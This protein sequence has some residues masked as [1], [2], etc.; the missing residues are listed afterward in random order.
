LTGTTA[1]PHPR[2]PS[3]R[4][5]LLRCVCL[6]N[7]ALTAFG[8]PAAAGLLIDG[9]RD[10]EVTVFWCTIKRDSTPLGPKTRWICNTFRLAQQANKWRN[11]GCEKRDLDLPGD[12]FM[13]ISS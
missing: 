1:T 2:L 11:T 6:V 5:W 4:Y 3:P 7:L 10:L 8:N 9:M 12:P 13:T